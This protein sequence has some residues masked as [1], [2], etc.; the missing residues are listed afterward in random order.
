MVSCPTILQ[1]DCTS[2]D[3]P[4]QAPH[5]HLS[6]HRREGSPKW[7]WAPSQALLPNPSWGLA[8]PRLYFNRYRPDPAKSNARS[9][10]KDRGPSTSPALRKHLDW[11]PLLNLQ[12]L[13]VGLRD[14]LLTEKSHP[15]L[16]SQVKKVRERRRLCREA[17]NGTGCSEEV[18]L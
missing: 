12:K 2:V 4:S 10:D 11:S 9:T 8:Q 15:G 16:P 14:E 7:W 6:K 1:G 5:G 17:R 13:P 3:R 18:G